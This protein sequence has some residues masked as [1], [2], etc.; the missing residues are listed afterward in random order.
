MTVLAIDPGTHESQLAARK[1]ARAAYAREWRRRN[2]GYDRKLRPDRSAY[3]AEYRKS[4]GY[5]AAMER[6]RS[7]E[8]YKETERKSR[9]LATPEKRQKMSA[10]WKVNQAVKSGS[11]Q[12]PMHCQRCSRERDLHAHH[13]DY[14]KPLDVKWLCVV[15]HAEEHR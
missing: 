5:A 4:A 8:K 3:S 12:K 11:L 2:P 6:Y 14:L 10:R 7:G 1:A 13:A 9:Q 15:C